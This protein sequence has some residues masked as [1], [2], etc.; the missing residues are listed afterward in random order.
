MDVPLGKPETVPT[1]PWVP[2]PPLPPMADT[3][4]SQLGLSVNFLSSMLSVLQKEGALDLDISTGMV[5]GERGLALALE[6]LSGVGRAARS[7][8][9]TP[10]HLRAVCQGLCYLR[11]KNVKERRGGKS[12]RCCW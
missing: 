6:G 12:L 10:S 9:A 5:S 8:H 3:S 4:S 2:M 1:P 7:C 11:A